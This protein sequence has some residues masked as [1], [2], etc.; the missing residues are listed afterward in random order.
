MACPWVADREDS[1]QI[2]R[3]VANIL[4]KL[5][6]TAIKWWFFILRV[7]QEANSAQCTSDMDRLF[8]MTYTTVNG[9]THLIQY[10]DQ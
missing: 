10:R 4:N 1:L 7:G 9:W 8:G 5:S 6:W 2:W 3:V